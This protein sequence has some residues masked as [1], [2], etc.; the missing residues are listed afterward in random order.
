[1]RAPTARDEKIIEAGRQRLADK[2][3]DSIDDLRKQLQRAYPN[4][5]GPFLQTLTEV[6]GNELGYID[7]IACLAGI[8]TE[9]RLE[10]LQDAVRA[11]KARA[12]EQHRVKCA[13][14]DAATTLSGEVFPN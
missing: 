9:A 7:G 11:G 5:M 13:G 14:C 1:M 12:L 2:I 6:L 8:P 10:I 3:G 4:N